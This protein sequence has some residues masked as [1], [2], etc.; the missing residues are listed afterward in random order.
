VIATSAA[1]RPYPRP[2]SWQAVAGLAF[3]AAAVGLCSETLTAVAEPTRAVIWGGL[4][5][6]AEAAGLLCLVQVGAVEAPGLGLLLFP[7]LVKGEDDWITLLAGLPG[8]L[9]VW[10]LAVALIFRPR[11]L[12]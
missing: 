9:L 5:L 3:F 8:T 7:S 2:V 1:K 12:T 4:G 10:L 6:A 11:R